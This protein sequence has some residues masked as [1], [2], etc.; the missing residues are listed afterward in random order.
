MPQNTPMT[1]GRSQ[2]L[3]ADAPSLTEAEVQAMLTG[4]RRKEGV[5]IEWGQTCQTL[6]KT[7]MNP[8]E[9]F[10]ATG[11]EPI[12]QNQIIVGAQVYA[13]M[14][15]VGVSED[16]ASHFRGRASD[17]LYEFRILNHADR[18]AAAVF[19][20]ERKMD[21]DEARELGKSMKDFSRLPLP[22]NFTHHPGDAVAY[23]VWQ[24]AK[25]K[26]DLQART[27]LIAKGL[28]FAHSL[29]ARQ[30]V[31][32][33]LM[34][35]GKVASRSAPRLPLYRLDSDEDMPRILPVAGHLPLSVA[36]LKAVPL[37]ESEPPFGMVKFAG[38]GAFVTVPG[39]QVIRTA[40]DPICLI[41]GPEQLP[42]PLPDTAP[43]FA[44]PVLVVV[45]RAQRQWQ[46]ESFFIAAVGDQV[47]IRWFEQP[48]EVALLGR[49]VLIMRPQKVL[50]E[51][52]T[53]EL[54]QLDE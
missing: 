21:M 31:E 28:R 1:E 14:L 32:A 17:V 41:C 40:E 20:F 9:I 49:V 54:W 25:T 10:E 12:Q 8:Q 15:S 3:G 24:A 48:P 52:Y 16:V 27:T 2:N 18:A 26:T 34:E 23:Y 5:W 46:A 7:G 42:A 11:F 44:E 30:Q 6:Q 53:N 45:N 22:E 50:D 35:I 36:D 51:D 37:V 19:A 38:A 43:G 4:L 47:E 39:W 33:L 29:S 13:S